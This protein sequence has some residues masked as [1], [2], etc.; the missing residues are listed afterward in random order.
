MITNDEKD[1]HIDETHEKEW[2]EET[3]SEEYSVSPTLEKS[4][5]KTFF[6]LES[7]C[8]NTRVINKEH[9]YGTNP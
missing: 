4:N 8:T 7:L 5:L 9:K 1:V 6:T 2:G 3:G